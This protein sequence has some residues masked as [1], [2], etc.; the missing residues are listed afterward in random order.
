VNAHGAGLGEEYTVP[1]GIAKIH[2]VK[3]SQFDGGCAN[4]G[5]TTTA[6]GYEDPLYA[7]DVMAATFAEQYAFFEERQLNWDNIT[8]PVRAELA[9]AVAAVNNGTTTTDD[10]LFG[11]ITSTMAAL[12]DGHVQLAVLDD[13]TGDI[14]KFFSSKDLEILTRL[15]Q[16]FTNQDDIDDYDTFQDTVLFTWL[17][18]VASFME[19]EA[20]SGDSDTLLWGKLEG[21]NVGYIMM[22]GFSYDDEEAYIADVKAAF[23][24]LQST[25]TIIFDIRVNTGGQDEVSLFIASYP[26]GELGS[27]L[28]WRICPFH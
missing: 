20:L 16:D 19:G 15:E 26:P 7:F 13:E 25:D 10:I 12:V 8:A 21:H 14:T 9:A 22:L 17:S 18:I 11:A 1:N 24:A 2:I 4:C 3:S 27:Q 28:S 5:V 23:T 6:D